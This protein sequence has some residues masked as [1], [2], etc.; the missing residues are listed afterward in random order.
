MEIWM[1]RAFINCWLELL[2]HSIRWIFAF[3]FKHKSQSFPYKG[4]TKV[5]EATDS[6]THLLT[7]SVLMVHTM[8]HMDGH[9]DIVSPVLSC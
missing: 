3:C 8:I 9:L 5:L 1:E 6:L 7:A 4:W 2:L